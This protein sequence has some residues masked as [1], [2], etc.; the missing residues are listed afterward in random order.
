[1]SKR[2]QVTEIVFIRVCPSGEVCAADLVDPA[3]DPMLLIYLG[4]RPRALAARL[5]IVITDGAEYWAAVDHGHRGYE[6]DYSQYPIVREEEDR[7]WLRQ[8]IKT[9]MEDKGMVE[10]QHR[11]W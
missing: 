1:M 6:I 3:V 4:P 2:Y 9:W 11:Q 10:K 5:L 8:E 7:E